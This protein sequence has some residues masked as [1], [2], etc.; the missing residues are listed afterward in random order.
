[1][2][3]MA[4]TDMDDMMKRVLITLEAEWCDCKP[5]KEDK[6]DK[7]ATVSHIQIT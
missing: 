2:A 3:D 4:N 7:V 6:F 1:M 5:A